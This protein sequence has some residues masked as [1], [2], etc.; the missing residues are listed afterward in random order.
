MEPR[1]HGTDLGGI[2]HPKGCRH[3]EYTVDGCQKM[4]PFGQ[5]P[6]DH[7]HGAPQE[8][9]SHF[10]PIAA[11]Q[12]DLPKFGGHAQKAADP[13]PEHRPGPAQADGPGD[14]DDVAGAHG[15]RQG[16]AKGLEGGNPL[17]LGLG[18][19]NLKGFP[20]KGQLGKL[21][22]EGQKNTRRQQQRRPKGAPKEIMK[23]LQDIR[24]YPPYSVWIFCL[25]L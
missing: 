14:P 13:H 24:L 17:P 9:P 8:F 15:G 21:C 3:A 4:E 11:R 12:G 5:A 2:A 1:G 23:R 22:P 16:G 25:F 18:T 10:H 7:V 6:G 20:E 19:E